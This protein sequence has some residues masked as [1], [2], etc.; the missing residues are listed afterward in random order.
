LDEEEMEGGPVVS[1]IVPPGGNTPLARARRMVLRYSLTE[2][3]GLERGVD[4]QVREAPIFW[5]I[6]TGLIALGA[7]VGVLI[8]RSAVVQ[9][10]LGVQVLNGVLL[11]LLLIFIIRLVNNREIMGDYVNGRIY[12]A[13]A[14][15]TVV[16]VAGL[17]LVMVAT[18]VL[19]TFGLHL[20][21]L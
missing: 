4:K 3:F 2:A 14:W 20:F 18:T 6:F 17:S 8:P 21:G 15:I 5:G 7:I 12:N 16:V 19:P 11:P 1:D 13:L 9:L 10:L